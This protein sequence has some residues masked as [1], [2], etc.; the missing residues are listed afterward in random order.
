MKTCLRWCLVRGL[1]VTELTYVS[2][3]NEL[4]LVCAVAVAPTIVQGTDLVRTTM[5]LWHTVGCACTMLYVPRWRRS[6]SRPVQRDSQC[7]LL[8]EGVNRNT[9][10]RPD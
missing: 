2:T 6:R 7:W 1:Y 9:G 10:R 8:L 5:V 3:C 4:P